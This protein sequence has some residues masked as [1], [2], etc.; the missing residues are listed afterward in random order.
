MLSDTLHVVLHILLVD[1][2]L[3][4]NIYRRHNIP[5]VHPVLKKSFKYSIQE[6][7]LATRSDLQYISFPL[8]ADIMVCQV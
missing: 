4:F 3:Q 6:E 8:S 5:L 1:K 2:S 7:Y